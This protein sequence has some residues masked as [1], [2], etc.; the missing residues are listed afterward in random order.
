MEDFE[1]SASFR[2]IMFLCGLPIVKVVVNFDGENGES[3]TMGDWRIE[4]V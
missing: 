4:K 3:C 2:E 1:S